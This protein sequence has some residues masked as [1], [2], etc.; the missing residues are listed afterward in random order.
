M[1]RKIFSM[2]YN[3]AIVKSDYVRTIL[4]NFT[5]FTTKISVQTKEISTSWNNSDNIQAMMFH[6]V[7]TFS[8]KTVRSLLRQASYTSLYD[9]ASKHQKRTTRHLYIHSIS[10]SHPLI[11][12]FRYRDHYLQQHCSHNHQYSILSQTSFSLKLLPS[13]FISITYSATPQP[14]YHQHYQQH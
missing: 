5:I 4:A 14:S 8:I 3:F 1:V 12:H 11:Y 10:L 13:Q 9:Q 6:P 2:V 7:S